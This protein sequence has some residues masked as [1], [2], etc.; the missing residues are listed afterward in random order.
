ML[1]QQKSNFVSSRRHSKNFIGISN[2][3][4]KE[5][6][7]YNW[8]IKI[9]AFYTDFDKFAYIQAY[10]S[11]FR[12]LCDPEIGRTKGIFRNLVYAELWHF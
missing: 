2:H 7:D 12:T 6:R 10:F 4:F 5:T 8:Y 11:I 1:L 9:K 3:A